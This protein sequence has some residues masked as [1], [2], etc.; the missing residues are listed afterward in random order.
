MRGF[1]VQVFALDCIMYSDHEFEQLERVDKFF[2]QCRYCRWRHEEWNGVYY[3]V[4]PSGWFEK[5]DLEGCQCKYTDALGQVLTA[6]LHFV[7]VEP[8]LQAYE[9]RINLGLRM[10]LGLLRNDNVKPVSYMG[11]RFDDAHSPQ[12]QLF[13]RRRQHLLENRAY[14]DVDFRGFWNA[15]FDMDDDINSEI[16]WV[17][18]EVGPTLQI[19][20]I[21]AV[22][23]FRGLKRYVCQF[24]RRMPKL[25]HYRSI[26]KKCDHSVLLFHF[27]DIFSIRT[28]G[29]LHC[30]SK[31][32]YAWSQH[33]LAWEG[34]NWL[35][36]F[37]GGHRAHHS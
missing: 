21:M 27:L 34:L 22:R 7:T 14:S 36:L 6:G 5:D 26:F 23:H 19:D 25:C 15:M 20:D 30:C 32:T 24:R 16:D 18:D 33:S 31:E 28:L 10:N 37:M 2:L 3:L 8:E 13:A 4:H 9:L 1:A 35:H 11:L 17:D 29:R 12:L